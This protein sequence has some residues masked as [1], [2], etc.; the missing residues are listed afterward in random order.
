MSRMASVLTLQLCLTLFGWAS[1]RKSAIEV[2]W[3]LVSGTMKSADTTISYSLENLVGMKMIAD[4]EWAVFG[5]NLGE[6][7]T[8]AY[9]GGGSYTLE[10]KY[11]TES[12]SY[13]IVKSRVGR[14][15]RLRS[16]SGTTR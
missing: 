7:E 5:E 15:I 4:N 16:K 12:I 11:Y 1:E 13:N 10:G 14:I 9:S 8:T 2:T 3:R 6:G